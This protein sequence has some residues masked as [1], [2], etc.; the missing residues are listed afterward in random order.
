LA[1]SDTHRFVEDYASFA[2]VC[3]GL[4][5]AGGGLIVAA[6]A[7]FAVRWRVL[8]PSPPDVPL[9]FFFCYLMI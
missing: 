3:V 4:V 2:A 9:R 7:I 8:F 6:I 5:L 1:R